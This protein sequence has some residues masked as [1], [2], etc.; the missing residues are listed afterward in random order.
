MSIPEYRHSKCDSAIG[1]WGDIA[2]NHSPVFWMSCAGDDD[3][4]VREYLRTWSINWL[5]VKRMAFQVRMVLH[6]LKS[7]TPTGC[8][9]P[10]T[11]TPRCVNI[12]AP[13]ASTNCQ[14]GR[15]RSRCAWFLASGSLVPNTFRRVVRTPEAPLLYQ[16][17]MEV[18][19]IPQKA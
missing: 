19:F 3:S 16:I 5:T 12:S 17:V 7:G 6:T 9:V 13:G 10:G 14:S 11:M 8:P 2:V 1:F 4:Q 15:W 18:V